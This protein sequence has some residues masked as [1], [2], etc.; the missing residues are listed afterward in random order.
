M[1]IFKPLCL[2]S[3]TPILL[4]CTV[5]KTLTYSYITTDSAPTPSAS[6]QDQQQLSSS[7]KDI[8][9]SLQNILAIQRASHPGPVLEPTFSP[10]DLGMTEPTSVDWNGP[11]EPLLKK[12]ALMSHYKL[13]VIGKRP[14]IPALVAISEEDVPLAD[15]LRNATYQL[16]HK[17]DINIDPATKIIELRY[18]SS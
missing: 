13:R 14:A 4:G 7:A 17:A 11:I 6:H 16:V 2:L 3:L 15:I 18:Y 12:I 5:H 10:A 9:H 8:D 1:K